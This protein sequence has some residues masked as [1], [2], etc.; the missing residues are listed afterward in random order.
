M[1]YRLY[2][3]VVITR[4]SRPSSQSKKAKVDK[5]LLPVKMFTITSASIDFLPIILYIND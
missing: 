1:V 3:V 5:K 2:M 4:L